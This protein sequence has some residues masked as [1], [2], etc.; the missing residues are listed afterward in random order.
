MSEGEEG[1]SGLSRRS[2]LGGVAAAGAALSAAGAAVLPEVASAA[3][4]QV[5]VAPKGTTAVE[6]M[7][8]IEQHGANLTGYGFL[9]DVAGLVPVELFFSEPENEGSAVFT[10]FANGHVEASF[11]R[12][13]VHSLDVHGDLSIYHRNQPGA[14]FSNPAS[15]KV[16][17]LVAHYTLTIQD[18]L[19]VISPGTGL[20]T[21]IGDLVQDQAAS[22]GGGHGKFGKVGLRLR[23]TGTGLGT[24]SNTDPAPP[25]AVLDIAGNL[26]VV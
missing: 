7:M 25:E 24:R 8:R 20:P 2:M 9:T 6:L 10:A 3:G 11:V 19:T 13:A 23:M 5:A 17:T 26:Q 15:F 16:G 12:N 18:V 21:L 14:S 22:I 4:G 1:K